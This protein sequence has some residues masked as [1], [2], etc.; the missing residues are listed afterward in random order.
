MQTTARY[1]A[2]E[3]R[4]ADMGNF[5]F[6]WAQRKRR[7]RLMLQVPMGLVVSSDQQV[8]RELAQAL[9]Q[10]ALSPVLAS[11]V[12]DGGTALA[13]NEISLVVC[14]DRLDDGQ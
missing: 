9:R 7:K 13:W 1:D 5:E 6:S 14:S 4:V 2:G 10:C 3:A 8:R 12:A 11:T